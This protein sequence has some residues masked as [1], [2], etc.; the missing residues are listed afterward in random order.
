ML[1]AL[2]EQ[3][4]AAWKARLDDDLVE[5]IACVQAAVEAT[6]GGSGT[7]PFGFAPEQLESVMPAVRWLYRQYFRVEAHG[8]EHVPAG[9]VL[10]VGNHSGQV[11]IDAS[12]VGA[13]MFLDGTPPRIPRAMIERWVP[14][15]P[16][17]STLFARVGQV[18][19]TPENCRRLLAD[20][21]AVLVFPEGVRG[22]NKTLSQR[23]QLQEFG[24]G[25]MRL[26]LE[27]NTP[28]V[29][30]AVV[31]AEEQYPVLYNAKGLAKVLGLPAVPVSP[32]MLAGPL[33]ALPLPV[34]YRI[35]F[36][37]PITFTGDPDDDEAV[38]G[39]QVGA[40][41]DAIAALLE[42]GL[43]ERKHLFW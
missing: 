34:K 4:K 27:T 1:G 10:V 43:G 23:Y 32:M 38:V 7:D 13:A 12:M 9:R 16:F 28:I 2:T 18:L 37:H 29:P 41:K 21:E 22:I 24:Q 42:R 35:Y 31:G 3:L 25:F 17:V 11:P 30:V 20:G 40:V 26:A 6:S 14:S 39:Q 8:L 33:G 36:G 5:R 15:L 19:G